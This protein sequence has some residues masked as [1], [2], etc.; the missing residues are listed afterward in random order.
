MTNEM[1][2]LRTSVTLG[3]FRH[4]KRWDDAGR[5]ATKIPNDQQIH[6]SYDFFTCIY[7]S[8]LGVG[9]FLMSCGLKLPYKYNT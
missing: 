7:F 5:L 1:F 3:S 2:K 9:W 6:Q 4:W 8:L